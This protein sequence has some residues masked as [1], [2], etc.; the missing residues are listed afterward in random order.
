M[1]FFFFF[2][3]FRRTPLVYESGLDQGYCARKFQ[4]PPQTKRTVL[5]SSLFIVQTK[6]RKT[7]VLLFAS[8][9]LGFQVFYHFTSDVGEWSG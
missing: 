5:K 3:H 4:W 8:T 6:A 2:F 7:T 9:Y 1:V